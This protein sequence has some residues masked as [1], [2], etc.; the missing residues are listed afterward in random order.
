MQHSEANDRALF[1]KTSQ[2]IKELMKEILQ[3]KND[4]PNEV[5][6]KFYIFF[7]NIN[8]LHIIVRDILLL[9]C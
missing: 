4:K 2:K 3:L 8:F 1:I 5:N 6:I 7:F 9:I